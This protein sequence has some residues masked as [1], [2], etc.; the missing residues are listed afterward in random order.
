MDEKGCERDLSLLERE[1]P[2]VIP[3]WIERI[4]VTQRIE[5]PSIVVKREVYE[6]LG[7]F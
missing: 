7:G 6:K 5:C 3:N 1:T 4:A 2:G